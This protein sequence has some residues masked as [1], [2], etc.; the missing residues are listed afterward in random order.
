MRGRHAA[1]CAVLC[2][3]ALLLPEV[4]LQD[5]G[6]NLLFFDGVCNLCDGFVTFVA[7]HDATERVRFGAIQRHGDRM[8]A[9][10]AETFAEGGSEALTTVVLIQDGAVFT[11][12]SAALRTI[13]L[14]DRPWRN[15]A[16]LYIIPEALRDAGYRFIA[17][18]RYRV[19]GQS[20]YCRAP[21]PRFLRRFLDAG[22]EAA[23]PAWAS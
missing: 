7:D 13:A 18:H 8:R 15:L 16:A 9:L 22:D 1:L 6:E 23:K 3:A 2:A 19:F 11:K 17:M 10:G 20:H 4:Y 12:S 5:D 14:L 21:T